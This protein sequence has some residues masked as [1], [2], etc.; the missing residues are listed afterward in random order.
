MDTSN[1]QNQASFVKIPSHILPPAHQLAGHVF[2]KGTNKLGILKDTK[3]SRLLKPLM[4]TRGPR[5]YEFYRKIWSSSDYKSLQQFMPKLLGLV[6]IDRVDFIELE[7]V[8]DGL[9]NP[10][11]MD[12]KIG[13]ITYDPFAD[14]EKIK[15]ETAKS[16]CS[17]VHGFRICGMRVCIIF[18]YV[19]HNN[20]NAI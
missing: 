10:S 4:D 8:T 12:I 6:T 3:T 13:L 2:G 9:Q 14:F 15:K 7:D 17:A 11:N 16:I 20:L 18:Y 1:E 5:E 19:Y